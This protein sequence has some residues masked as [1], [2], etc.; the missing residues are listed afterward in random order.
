[1][2]KTKIKREIAEIG[3]GSVKNKLEFL[4]S[5]E[6]T[7]LPEP[8]MTRQENI[9][10]YKECIDGFYAWLEDKKTNPFAKF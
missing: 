7:P 10:A 6:I 4:A 1:M 3:I 5:S 9:F 2:L 8:G